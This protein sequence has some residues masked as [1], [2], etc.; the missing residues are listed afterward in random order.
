MFH[1]LFDVVDCGGESDFTELAVPS[2]RSNGGAVRALDNGVHGLTNGPLIVESVVNTCVVGVVVR[3][4]DAVLDE[5]ANTLD[6]TA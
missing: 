5:R 4:E 1:G 2:S 3:C 6:H